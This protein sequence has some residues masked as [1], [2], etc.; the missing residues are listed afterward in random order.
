MEKSSGYFCVGELGYVRQLIGQP[1]ILCEVS[2]LPGH[3][4]D[5]AIPD[6]FIDK[7]FKQNN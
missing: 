3:A 2:S 6:E 4:A 5:P 1:V 7:E